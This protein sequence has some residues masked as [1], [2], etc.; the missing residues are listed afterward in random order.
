MKT[1]PL[2]RNSRPPGELAASTPSPQQRVRWLAFRRLAAERRCD[3]Q[4][5]ADSDAKFVLFLKEYEGDPEYSLKLRA[6]Y[7]VAL[8]LGVAREQSECL[9]DS[10]EDED[11]ILSPAGELVLRDYAHKI[12]VDHRR[13]VEAERRH[14][15]FDMLFWDVRT[16]EYG[17]EVLCL[18][19]RWG[20][21]T[22]NLETFHFDQRIPYAL[23]TET[24]DLFDWGTQFE[25]LEVDGKDVVSYN[26]I[27]WGH[28]FNGKILEVRIDGIT[29]VTDAGHPEPDPLIFEIRPLRIED[30]A[31]EGA[32]PRKTTVPTTTEELYEYFRS[33]GW[34]EAEPE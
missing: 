5:V 19:P 17:R 15:E 6:A 10:L 26:T 25:L 32:F 16:S 23:F 27:E 22:P 12:V 21:P 9:G 18:P 11:G 7:H 13:D 31:W 30:S 34:I 2:S 1:A 29:F 3:W 8:G 28:T 24:G 33:E 20:A 4:S 14:P